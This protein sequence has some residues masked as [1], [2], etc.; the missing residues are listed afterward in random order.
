M[1]FSDI[2]WTITLVKSASRPDSSDDVGDG[3]SG[4]GCALA[5]FT[6]LLVIIV[7]FTIFC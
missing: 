3:N 4:F 7:S 5:I 1:K 6:A 2:F